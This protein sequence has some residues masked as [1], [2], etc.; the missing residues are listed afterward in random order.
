MKN[1]PLFNELLECVEEIFFEAYSGHHMENVIST[2][3]NKEQS[4]SKKRDHFKWLQYMYSFW[5]C[6]I[7][8][9]WYYRN[10]VTFNNSIISLRNVIDEI[11]CRLRSWLCVMF[12]E[13]KAIHFS[14]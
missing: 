10:E 1:E 9:I 11:K 14:D 7:W 4:Y 12:F 6:I 5:I 2:I 13:V 3:T 8:T